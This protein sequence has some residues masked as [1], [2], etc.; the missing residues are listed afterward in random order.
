MITAKVIHRIDG[1]YKGR[2]NLR[3]VFFVPDSLNNLHYQSAQ[4]WA[5]KGNSVD[6]PP[7]RGKN[8]PGKKRSCHG[9]GETIIG[10]VDPCHRF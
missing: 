1:R 8:P 2:D 4:D 5:A 9:F 10:R 3:K 6:P 7:F